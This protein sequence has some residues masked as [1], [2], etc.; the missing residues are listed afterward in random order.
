MAWHGTAWHSIAKHGVAHQLPIPHALTLQ[1][2]E[3][4][5]Y[6]SWT[7]ITRSP[8]PAYVWLQCTEPRDQD[9]YQAMLNE[10]IKG[11]PG[12]AFGAGTEYNRLELLMQPAVFDSMAA[13][14]ELFV[15]N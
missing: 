12:P 7:Q 1:T 8:A 13:K 4:A 15:A 9:C 5:Q 14:L 6:D 3:A 11:R 2:L 10:G